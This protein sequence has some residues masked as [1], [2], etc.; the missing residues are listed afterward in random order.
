VGHHR[1]AALSVLGREV[2]PEVAVFP[3]P[4]FR[5]LKRLSLV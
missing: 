2:M 5:A 4:A 3:E 1:A